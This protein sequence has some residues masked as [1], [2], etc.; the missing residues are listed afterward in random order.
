[1]RVLMLSKA[2]V[3]G[4]YQRKAEELAK[5]GV[6]LLVVTPPS[7]ILEGTPQV[8]ERQYTSGYQL[9]VEPIALNGHFHLHFY[10]RLGRRFAAFLPELVH[11]DEEAYNLA[12]FQ[13]VALARRYGARSVF[14]T[15]QNLDRRY[16][17]PFSAMERYVLRSAD[18]CIA[19]NQEAAEIQRR[20]HFAKRVRVIPQFGVDPELFR[21]AATQHDGFVAGFA[22][23]LVPQKG[24]WLLCDAFEQLPA[25][26]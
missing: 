7:W 17:W 1:M 24:L 25:D 23:R 22:G 21:P 12:T 19:G 10:P 8:L 20:R 18:A 14:F 15:W 13:T 5:L 26:S 2:L 11:V 3:V 16:P 9:A 4:A 6:E